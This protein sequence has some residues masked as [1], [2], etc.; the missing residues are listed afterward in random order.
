MVERTQD[1]FSLEEQKARLDQ[2]L[3]S[4]I[5]VG[6]GKNLNETEIDYVKEYATFGI[7]ELHKFTNRNLSGYLEDLDITN[8]VDKRKNLEASGV[9]NYRIAGLESRGRYLAEIARGV[10]KMSGEEK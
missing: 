9:T 3:K 5:E 6:R 8:L 10:R 7:Q 2:A 1:T 4:Y